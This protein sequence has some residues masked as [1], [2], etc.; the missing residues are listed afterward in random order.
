MWR[1]WMPS[2]FT[3]LAG[4]GGSPFLLV[5]VGP[6]GD[7]VAPDF[8]SLEVSLSAEVDGALETRSL[9]FDNASGRSLPASF[10]L[11]FDS[12]R[13]GLP[14]SVVV[15]GLD[16]GEEVFSASGD[17]VVG[18]ELALTAL[19]CGDGLFQAERGE[20]CDDQNRTNG[21]GCRDDCTE[22]RC[23]DGLTDPGE[24][25]D[26]GNTAN[27][28][29]CQADCSAEACGD[30]ILDSN[31]ECD[32]ANNTDDDGCDADCTFSDVV[33]LAL[34]D[35]HSCALLDTGKVRCWGDNQFGQ[36][37]YGNTFDIGDNEHPFEAG[38]VDLGG[39]RAIKIAAG[40]N[41][42]CA[43][44]ENFTAICW[45]LNTAGQLGY[46][47]IDPVGNDETPG[48]VG[49]VRVLSDNGFF[50]LDIT[51]G[52]AHTCAEI[53]DEFQLT[54]E[55]VCWGLNAAGQL[56][57]GNTLNVGD[58]KVL[59]DLVPRLIGFDGPDVGTITAGGIHNCLL[60]NGGGRIACWGNGAQGQLGLRNTSN[61]GDNES[62]SVGDLR[63]FQDNS[64]AID[65]FGNTTCAVFVSAVDGFGS[66][67]CWGQGAAGNLGYGERETIGDN[68]FA[69]AAPFISLGLNIRSVSVGGSIFCA[70]SISGDIICW[71][72]ADDSSFLGYGSL[73]AIGDDEVPS[74]VGPLEMGGVV[75]Q[76]STGN[77][78]ACAVYDNGRVRCWGVGLDGRLGYRSTINLGGAETPAEIP[79]VLVNE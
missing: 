44:L 76:V 36:L 15:S 35:K 1:R 2:V 68:E 17:G 3:L 79:F 49:P 51:A 32:D 26:D 50:P 77:N 63:V 53:V 73:S 4:C 37:G 52:S 7:T 10:V 25:C 66:V 67:R 12:S 43:V 65:S 9:V 70:L 59:I 58:N 74:D 56:G 54:T 40:A 13:A 24:D 72:G 21:D 64:F 28:D 31:E 11:E 14:V 33:Q 48:E 41:H 60:E 6:P 27:G 71:G 8:D 78:H 55:I 62:V 18:E 61:I 5:E 34:G 39:E 46:G 57:Y 20:E 75:T 29:G 23:G 38:D 19:F 47:N 30:G 22:E 16:Q 45:G 42:T 69:S